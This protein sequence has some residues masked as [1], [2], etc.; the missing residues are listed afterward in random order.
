[1]PS[2]L[3]EISGSPGLPIVN[4]VNL[5]IYASNANLD[6]YPLMKFAAMNVSAA[7]I[8]YH[9]SIIAEMNVSAADIYYHCSIIVELN[10][11]AADIYYHCS[12][13]AEMNVSAADIY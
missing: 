9:C 11:S 10:V 2:F 12:I 7:D 3:I 6:N 13:I 1:M 4:Y 5:T 8:Y